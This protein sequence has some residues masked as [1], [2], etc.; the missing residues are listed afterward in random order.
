MYSWAMTKLFFEAAKA[1]GPQ[2]TRPKI[3]EFVRGHTEYTGNGLFPPQNYQSK[4]PN[5]CNLMTEVEGGSF[6]RRY[7]ANG[8]Y[9]DGGAYDLT[10]S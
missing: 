6:V 10:P 9:C 8:Y 2:L 5:D 1:A 3:L 7:P 4:V